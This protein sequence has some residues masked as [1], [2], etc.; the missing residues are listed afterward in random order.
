[1]NA[2]KIINDM[3]MNL[4]HN[5]TWLADPAAGGVI[6]KYDPEAPILDKTGKPTGKTY[7]KL[8]TT[9]IFE[10]GTKCTCSNSKFDR[11][12]A[13]LI[14][15]HNGVKLPEPVITADDTAKEIGIINC[16]YKRLIGTINAD[17]TINGS[18]GAKWLKHQITKNSYDQSVME[19]YGKAMKKLEAEKNEAAHRA[20]AKKAHQ[21][22][23]KR[24]AHRL[25]LEREAEELLAAKKVTK[26]ASAKPLC[27]TKITVKPAVKTAPGAKSS[28]SGFS[29]KSPT[30]TEFFSR[31]CKDGETY[32]RPAKRFADFT[33]E[34]KRAYWRA[35]KR[36][37]L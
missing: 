23:V 6:F 18:G 30:A 11:V 8:T 34:E 21:H 10:D 27:E 35:Q 12:N 29:K 5:F 2:S 3:V 1:M 13:V 9:I 16:L 24:L 7:G 22:K 17:G 26:M 33:P 15:E 32:V 20:A 19:V 31:S 36:G 14:S 28:I 4:N 25:A 37:W